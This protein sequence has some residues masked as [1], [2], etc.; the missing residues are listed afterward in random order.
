MS[1]FKFTSLEEITD[2]MEMSI[3]CF[4]E[5][6]SYLNEVGCLI[7]GDRDMHERFA[8]VCNR[9]TID[10]KDAVKAMKINKDK[11]EKYSRMTHFKIISK[12]EQEQIQHNIY[13]K[14]INEQSMRYLSIFIQYVREIPYMFNEQKLVFDPSDKQCAACIDIKL[15]NDNYDYNNIAFIIS[16]DIF[17]KSV[18]EY[19]IKNNLNEQSIK[20]LYTL[21]ITK[22]DMPYFMKDRIDTNGQNRF[23]KDIQLF[24]PAMYDRVV[25]MFNCINKHIDFK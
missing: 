19:V 22:I 2:I 6:N 13:L 4:S 9:T 8:D 17:N 11:E 18:W 7:Q 15:D 20:E 21:L 16:R 3:P 14:I 5:F 25:E 10:K 24:N 23:I 1:T 12:E